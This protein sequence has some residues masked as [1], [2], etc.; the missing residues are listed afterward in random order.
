VVIGKAYA[1]GH[2]AGLVWRAINL[3]H[4]QT[5][6]LGVTT[7]RPLEFVERWNLVLMERMGGTSMKRIL[8]DATSDKARE[9]TALAA[10]AVAA[11]H[12]LKFEGGE[13]IRSVQS[14]L[15]KMRKRA[16]RLPQVAPVLAEQVDVLMRRIEPLAGESGAVEPSF[17]HGDCKPSQLLIDGEQVAIVDF[18]RACLGD[19]ALDIGNFMAQFN[20]LALKKGHDHLRHLASYFLAEYQA[21]LPSSGLTERARVFQAMSLVRMAI[22][23]FESSPHSYAEKGQSSDHVSLLR[24]AA[25]CLD[26]L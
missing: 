13:E 3:L 14:A 25:L 2:V 16:V 26:Q 10:T 21:R 6:T 1:D 22:R 12:G 20:K 4:A 18:D 9:V 24:E 7:P 8:E 5:A 15:E 17:I 11:Y 19:P 23:K